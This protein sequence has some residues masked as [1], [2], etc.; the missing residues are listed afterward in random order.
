MDEAYVEAILVWAEGGPSPFVTRWLAAHGVGSTSMR[1]GL[2][3]S[4]PM[5]AFER[6]FGVELRNAE[7]PVSLPVPRDLTE[8]VASITI[9]RPRRIGAEGGQHHGP[10]D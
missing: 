1:A 9:P 2:L 10:T 7:P 6:S 8:V 4:G 5:A 3:V